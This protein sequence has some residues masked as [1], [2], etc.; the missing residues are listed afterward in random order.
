MA[1]NDVTILK[2]T[3]HFDKDIDSLYPAWALSVDYRSL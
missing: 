2:L 3:I 1:I